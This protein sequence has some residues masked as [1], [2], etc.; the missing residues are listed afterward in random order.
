MTSPTPIWGLGRATDPP[1]VKPNR[2]IFMA[3]S[4]KKGKPTGCMDEGSIQ[5]R[6]SA[7][8]PYPRKA[9]PTSSVKVVSTP[10]KPRMMLL[11]PALLRVSL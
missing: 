11:Y 7:C 8:T 1:A 10:E 9:L 6:F 3:S 5:R 2:D 4:S